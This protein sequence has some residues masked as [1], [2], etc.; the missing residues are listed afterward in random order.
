MLYNKRTE[1][2]TSQSLIVYNVIA[3]YTFSLF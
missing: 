3:K 1:K 2:I